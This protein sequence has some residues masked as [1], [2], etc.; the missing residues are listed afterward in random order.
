MGYPVEKLECWAVRPHHNIVIQRLHNPQDDI[1]VSILAQMSVQEHFIEIALPTLDYLKVGEP[2]DWFVD[3]TTFLSQSSA[4]VGMIALPGLRYHRSVG[5]A[6]VK[7][8]HFLAVM[9]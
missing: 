3:P 1:L 4:H 2:Q 7:N 6:L 5:D 8:P 9:R